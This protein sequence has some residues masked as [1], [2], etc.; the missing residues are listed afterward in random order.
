MSL[1]EVI[2]DLLAGLAT[3]IQPS[4]QMY[5]SL[6]IPRTPPR[7]SGPHGAT[8][9]LLRAAGHCGASESGN[10]SGRPLSFNRCSLEWGPCSA[11]STPL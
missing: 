9:W 1:R 3:V 11:F 5:Q 4:E 2:S 8:T 10:T 6:D 7:T